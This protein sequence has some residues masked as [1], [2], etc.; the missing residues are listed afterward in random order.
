MP[1]ATAVQV[2]T[3]LQMATLAEKRQPVILKLCVAWVGA[4]RE[5]TQE[6][7][8]QTSKQIWMQEDFVLLY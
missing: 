1:V 4:G 7:P 8:K 6:L 5:T 3:A 2:A